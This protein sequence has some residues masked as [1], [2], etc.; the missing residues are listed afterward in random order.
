MSSLLE[1]HLESQER[2]LEQS[3]NMEKIWTDRN[4][5]GY[6]WLCIYIYMYIYTWTFAFGGFD[7]LVG[8]LVRI[9]G[10]AAGW[11]QH[12]RDGRAFAQ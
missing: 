4:R 10:A 8:D 5:C 6:I 11:R 2:S 3:M 12:H 1:S 7:G 9:A